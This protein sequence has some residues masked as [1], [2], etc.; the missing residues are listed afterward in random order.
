M[1]ST[2]TMP[3]QKWTTCFIIY[4]LGICSTMTISHTHTHD[5]YLDLAQWRIVPN[6]LFSIFYY[7]LPWQYVILIPMTSSLT[8]PNAEMVQIFYYLSTWTMLYHDNKSYSYPWHLLGPGS[9]Q[10]W[11]R[12]FI[13]YVLEL[14]STMTKIS[15]TL[16]HDIYLD[17]AQ[18]RSGPNILLSIYLN[19]ALPWQ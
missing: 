6:V 12:Y 15:H 18:C 3:M 5:I 1:I 16:T 11:F 13:I 4:Q 7:D 19:Y 10:K 14:C 2:S 9:M 17:I 8:S